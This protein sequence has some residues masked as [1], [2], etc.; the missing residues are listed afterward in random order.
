MNVENGTAAAQFPEKKII[1]GIFVAVRL[2]DRI[3]KSVPVRGSKGRN[4]DHLWSAHFDQ[5]RI[6]QAIDNMI[7]EKKIRD[8][9]SWHNVCRMNKS[10]VN[11]IKFS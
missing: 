9:S 2:V 4:F 5:G 3:E 7:P 10:T 1:N 6:V 11:I 8:V